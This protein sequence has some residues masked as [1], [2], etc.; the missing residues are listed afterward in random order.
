[1]ISVIAIYQQQKNYTYDILVCFI[2]PRSHKV[3]KRVASS[4]ICSR[5]FCQQNLFHGN[6]NLVFS[7]FL[8]L[9]YKCELYQ[10]FLTFCKS[11]HGHCL[12]SRVSLGFTDYWF[13]FCLFGHYYAQ[14]PYNSIWKVVLKESTD[15]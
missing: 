1:M 14:K 9:L 6:I 13:V 11:L 8:N 3:S 12:T 4:L 15:P 5:N 2:K 10:A 7:T